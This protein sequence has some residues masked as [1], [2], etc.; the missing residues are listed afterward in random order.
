KRMKSAPSWKTQP[1]GSGP[2]K[3]EP[4]RKR[5]RQPRSRSPSCRKARRCKRNSENRKRSDEWLDRPRI[6]RSAERAWNRDPSG[7]S[8]EIIGEST[9]S[10]ATADPPHGPPLSY[11]DERGLSPGDADEGVGARLLRWCLFVAEDPASGRA[12]LA[13]RLHHQVGKVD[14]R[15]AATQSR[16]HWFNPRY[17]TW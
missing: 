17:P 12:H 13:W 16:T 10:L 14:R 4:R 7:R 11:V 15:S 3:G 9:E 2:S 1:N 8:P 5:R 6:V